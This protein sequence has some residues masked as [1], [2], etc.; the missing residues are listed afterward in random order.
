MSRSRIRGTKY[1]PALD[2]AS[3]PPS[4]GSHGDGGNVRLPSPPYKRVEW[5][6]DPAELFT[7][8]LG[9]C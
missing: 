7:A 5:P 8:W 3:S 6:A 1:E 4:T 9:Q 2:S